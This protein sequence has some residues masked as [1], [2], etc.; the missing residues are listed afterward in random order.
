MVHHGTDG[1]LASPNEDV[2]ALA[3]TLRAADAA[4]ADA[5]RTDDGLGVGQ[6]TVLRAVADG[7]TELAE[8]GEIAGRDR[9][10]ISVAV[11]SLVARGLLE[12]TSDPRDRRRARVGLTAAGADALARVAAR[13][14]RARAL[15][16]AALG[17]EGITRLTALL[18]RL[19]SG[20]S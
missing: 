12:R 17:E 13:E 10:T 14:E 1:S 9:S 20:L 18:E 19:R 2:A 16:G 7:T 11:R 3:H 15:V 5:V 6:A 8:L 4:W